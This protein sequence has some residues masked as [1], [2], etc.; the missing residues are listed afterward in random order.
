M[1]KEIHELTRFLSG[2]ITTPSESDIPKE[3]ASYSL[4][5]D[6]NTENGKL[7]GLPKDAEHIASLQASSLGVINDSGVHHLIHG[8][9]DDNND[10]L[11]SIS[12]LYGNKTAGT[13]SQITQS[14]TPLAITPNNKEVHIG[15]GMTSSDYPQWAGI[16]TEPQFGT[17]YSGVQIENAELVPPGGTAPEVYNYVSDGTYF[18]GFGLR[19][20]YLYKFKRSDGSIVSRKLIG[21]LCAIADADAFDTGKLWVVKRSPSGVHSLLRV[22]KTSLTTT[23]SNLFNS[24]T[25]PSDFYITDMIE[26][27]N[28]LWFAAYKDGTLSEGDSSMVLMNSPKPSGSGSLSMTDKTPDLDFG[29]VGQYKWV[30]SQFN[31][32]NSTWEE[33]ATTQQI[34]ATYKRSLVKIDN[35]TVGWVAKLKSPSTRLFD[36]SAV[37]Y[38]YILKIHSGSAQ[39]P[40]F[41]A[42]S[43]NGY[44]DF[45]NALFQIP[46][47]YNA[48]SGTYYVYSVNSPADETIDGIFQDT[49]G[50]FIAFRGGTNPS[51][52][53]WVALSAQSSSGGSL[54][55]NSTHSGYYNKLDGGFSILKLT[56]NSTEYIYGSN[57]VS[58]GFK[59]SRLTWNNG[60][61]GEV[62][63]GQMD[64]KLT[65]AN[66][67]GDGLDS[68]KKYYYKIGYI[69]D[70]YQESPLSIPNWISSGSAETRKITVEIT[71]SAV[72]KRATHLNIYR[73]ES[74]SSGTAETSFY[75]LVESIPLDTTWTGSTT[76]E[77]L[78][79]DNGTIGTSYEAATG[80]AENVRNTIVHY[81]LSAKLNGHL[82]VGKTFH[83]DLEDGSNYIFKS[84]PL[85]LDQ[86]NVLADFLILPTTPTALASFNGRVFAFDENNTYRISGDGMYVEDTFNGSGCLGPD[87]FVVTEYGMCFADHNNIYL[88]N[89][90][91]P[92][93]IGDPILRGDTYAWQSRDTAYKSNVSFDGV[94]N[95]FVITFKKGTGYYAW[96]YSL[97][98]KRWDL[99][100]LGTAE[101]K[102]LVMGKN[103][104]ILFAQNGKLMHLFGNSE[105]R[106]WQYDSKN[107]TLGMDTVDKMYYKIK[108]V[109]DSGITIGHAFD[110]GSFPE[111]YADPDLDL[112]STKAKSL[113][114]SIKGNN[115]NEG[116]DNSLDAIGIIYRRLPI[117]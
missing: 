42:G 68:T 74:A 22:D 110:G 5:I 44:L 92:Q 10:Y 36:G 69:Y 115:D 94:R 75:R 45:D 101:P 30:R 20:T 55:G 57:A 102:A 59:I 111:S 50:L 18:Y 106:D 26:T 64:V 29:A 82:F 66:N 12:D 79:F 67:G 56:D 116:D 53:R 32:N 9:L 54:L 25:L 96:M 35:T 40:E 43:P 98:M 104:E 72:P 24:F 11:N 76:K 58:G 100:G 23:A 17:T 112:S 19:D 85:K 103:G 63:I 31:T 117:K 93:P 37:D 91:Q 39:N 33:V 81:G 3:A 48:S 47:N 78:V 73:A 105:K 41:N 13:A 86:F 95:A 107:I 60:F 2:T 84:Q 61:S 1:P 8:Y 14:V 49:D 38:D 88:H 62:E 15:T 46:E 51:I 99:I 21:E 71:A 113:K 109:A 77:K 16:I 83:P 34:T 27:T 7:K 4:N 6:P 90:S 114:V 28:K 80:I 108:T 97:S 65:I 70:G 87:A 52:K 89:G